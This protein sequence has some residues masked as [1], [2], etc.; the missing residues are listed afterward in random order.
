[1][2]FNFENG[3]VTL[4]PEAMTVPEI[5][6]LYSSDHDR[7]KSVFN[8]Y[9]TYIFYVYRLGG[10]YEHQFVGVRKRLTCVHQLK[11]SE[12]YWQTIENNKEVMA[13][14][15]WYIKYSKSKEE[16]LLEAL[17]ADIEHYL[18]YLKK[19]PYTKQIRVEES[20][21]E[22]KDPII[23]YRS[24]DNSDEKMKAIKNSRELV[25]YRK[26]LRK[27]VKETNMKRKKSGNTFRTRQYENV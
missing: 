24:E 19:I 21:G 13:V 5:K 12:D 11:K 20:Q 4:V 7:S 22:D 2:I 10:I 16:Q 6:V 3:K 23:T 18:D 8:N 26:E 27:L 15:D 17:D 1:M 14:I 25:M 9:I